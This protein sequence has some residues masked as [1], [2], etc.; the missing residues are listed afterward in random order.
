MNQVLANSALSDPLP[1]AV[2]FASIPE[3]ICALKKVAH[4][5]E[6]KDTEYTNG[7]PP[8]ADQRS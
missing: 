7:W 6:L 3:V 1:A 2:T 8:M 4:L 5:S